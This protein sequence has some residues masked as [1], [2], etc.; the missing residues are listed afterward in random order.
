MYSLNLIIEKNQ[1][2]SLD[3]TSM[4]IRLKV[5]V[6]VDDDDGARTDLRLSPTFCHCFH[7]LDHHITFFP[8]SLP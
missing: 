7:F 3:E 5:D 2:A 4:L 6:D 8:V 1:Y